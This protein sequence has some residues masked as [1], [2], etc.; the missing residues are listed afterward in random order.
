MLGSFDIIAFF[1]S[2]AAACVPE[3]P[4]NLKPFIGKKFNTLD[5]RIAF[6]D[7]Y[8]FV[9][10]AWTHSFYFLIMCMAFRGLTYKQQFGY[11]G[12]R[13]NN[14][15]VAGWRRLILVRVELCT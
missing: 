8:G 10:I 4:D 11:I 12:L 9:L 15:L 7:A 13:F 2:C 3:C 1:I 14:V 6:Y 5:A